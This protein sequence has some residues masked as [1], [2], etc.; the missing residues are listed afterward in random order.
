MIP[1]LLFRPQGDLTKYLDTPRSRSFTGRICPEKHLY[2]MLL[3]RSKVKQLT[4][5]AAEDDVACHGFFHNNSY[6]YS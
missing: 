5:S 6:I 1:F 3:P 4:L 2:Y